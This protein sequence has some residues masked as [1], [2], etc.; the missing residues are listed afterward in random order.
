MP[1]AYVT[2]LEGNSD[3][4]KGV[5]ALASSLRLHRCVHPLVVGVAPTT[6]EETFDLLARE[7]NVRAIR[8]AW[9]ELPPGMAD[10]PVYA[11]PQFVRNF[12]KLRLWELTEYTKLVYLDADTLAFANIDDMFLAPSFSAALDNMSADEA[13]SPE[14]FQLPGWNAKSA[15]A[16]PDRTYFNAGVMVFEPSSKEYTA[17]MKRLATWEPTRFAE[18]DFLNDW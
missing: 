3:Y 11:N 7:S 8:I 6:S 18:Q 9:L 4:S 12:T 13:F 14:R 2:F 16:E 10:S 5:I 1:V 15:L 17:M